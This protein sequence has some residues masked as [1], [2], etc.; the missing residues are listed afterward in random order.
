VRHSEESLTMWKLFFHHV[1]VTTTNQYITIHDSSCYC[2]QFICHQRLVERS[3]YFLVFSCCNFKNGRMQTEKFHVFY[4]HISINKNTAIT[5]KEMANTY[6][7]N[8]RQKL[9][10]SYKWFKGDNNLQLWHPRSSTPQLI[11]LLHTNNAD[12]QTAVVHILVL[13]L[14]LY[15]TIS[16]E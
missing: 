6:G 14:K 15:Y 10:N 4:E 3:L 5:F 12:Q 8:S 13:H 16:D 9:F 11:T 1:G 7:R 2:Q